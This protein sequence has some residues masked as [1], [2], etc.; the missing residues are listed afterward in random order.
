MAQQSKK[1]FKMDSSR[2]RYNIGFLFLPV[3]R[4]VEKNSTGFLG[5]IAVLSIG[6]DVRLLENLLSAL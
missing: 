1:R 5:Y 4:R 3:Q 2:Q 6:A